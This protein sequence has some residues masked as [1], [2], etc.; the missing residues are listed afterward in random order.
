[1]IEAYKELAMENEAVELLRSQGWLSEEGDNARYDKKRALFPDDV[2]A[3]LEATQPQELAK[4]VKSDM[5]STLQLKARDGILDALAS[6]LNASV[7]G[8]GGTLNILRRGFRRISSR[9][10]MAQPKPTE[11]LN[12]KT[13]EDYQHNRFRVIRQVHYSV[14]DSK[15]S[16][17]LVLFLNGLPVATIEL[18]TE[19][20]QS[21][22]RGQVQY[23]NDRNPG[24][25]GRE[26]LLAWGKRT[27]VHFVVTDNEVSMTTKLDGPKTTFLPF[28]QGDGSAKGNPINPH[29]ARTEYLWRDILDK[30]MFLTILT[31]YL[32]TR[33]DE[34]P[35]PVTGKSETS[36]S[37]RFPRFHQLTVVEKVVGHISEH[38]V[39][40]RYLIEHS[41][42]SGKTDSIVWTSFRLAALHDA[43]N[44]KVFD[45]VIVL[46]DRNVLDKQMT[47]AMRQLDPRG[48]QV[49]SI[50]GAGS[51]KS[52]ELAE[53]L[54]LRTPIIVVTIQTAPFALSYLRQQSEFAGGRYA[55]IADE[56]H[57]SQAGMAASKLKAVLSPQEQESLADGGEVD[58]EAILA[59]ELGQ[60]AETPNLSYLA[61]T[62]TPKSK[63]LELFGTPNTKV[64]DEDG[65]PKPEPFH[66]YTMRQAIEEEFILD[67]LQ[68]FTE[69]RVAY[70]L[71]LK[72]KDEDIE[73]VDKEAARKAAVKWVQLHEYNISQKVALIVEHFRD[74][75]AHM[76]GGA[77]KAMIVTS[78][79][80]AALRYYN[81]VE[82]YVTK[83]GYTDVHALVAFS[84]KV[85]VS[86]DDEDMAP[87]DL[88]GVGEYT[89]ASVN[90]GTRGKPLAD[91]FNGP[92]YQVMIVANKFQVGFDQPLLCAMYVDKRLDGVMAVQ[93]LS[94]L[95]RTWPGKEHV[96]VLD[97]VNKGEDILNAFQ[98]YYEGAEL[99]RM[100]DPDLV[101]RIAAKLD[102]VGLH[103]VY[104]E[105]EM[106]EAADA[107]T[108]GLHN[109]L[110]AAID[111]A[112]KRFTALT[113]NAREDGND[114]EVQSLEIFRYDLASYVKAYDFLSQIVPYGIEMEQR[115][116]YYRFLAKRLHNE[117]S[118]VKVKVADLDL[119]HYKIEDM[120]KQKLDL[121]KSEATPLTPLAEMGTAEARERD[122]AQ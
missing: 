8:G 6:S 83:C 11:T 73:S 46:T 63:T 105:E 111:P 61:F 64:L 27:L 103:H 77:A 100:T 10:S 91:A 49:V 29:G 110:T 108:K 15:K 47:D 62:A 88:L 51:S 23:K 56:A 12:P 82:S 87:D 30:D 34:R 48:A 52:R 84:G 97:F 16:I 104:T 54:V 113:A 76:L 112:A 2:F 20:T 42:G 102:E 74:N 79:R 13:V 67:V 4:L 106:A 114:L 22:T 115:A 72:T 122:L 117:Q 26:I 45:S 1:M 65:N 89:E 25:D 35:N 7:D 75:L 90:A 80:K 120:G 116:I 92:A 86:N 37:L 81:A 5:D 118:G 57:S 44:K 50:D 3:W 71:A 78:S 107:A 119:T 9:F 98:P 99:T 39:G 68:N 21:V 33:K 85:T 69:Y 96:Y 94:R 41:A 70:E 53:A 24:A 101:N 95:N 14:T 32:V 93:T 109:A 19:F 28:N 40:E 66:R 55:V 31:K 58:T 121:A 18:K 59:A 38:G 60:R 36:I 43:E 17:D